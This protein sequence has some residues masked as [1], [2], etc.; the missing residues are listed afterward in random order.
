MEIDG[1]EINQAPKEY[2][3]KNKPMKKAF[4]VGKRAIK[5]TGRGVEEADLDVTPMMNFFMILIPFLVSMAIFTQIAVVDF[6]L[7]P[8]SAGGESGEE[9]ETKELD[10]SIVVTQSGFQIVGTGRKLDM[11]PK[12]QGDY[13]FNQLRVLLKA[14]KFQYPSQKSVV[15]V[16]EGEVLYDDI[17][18]FMDICRESQFPD[19][20]L[21]G[22]IG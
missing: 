1:I 20:G 10:I 13:Q 16:F 9:K 2:D 19:I 6:S 5:G 18:K 17:I 21:S 11:I 22:D 3:P 12:L 8:S 4:P 7:P 14:I 15:L